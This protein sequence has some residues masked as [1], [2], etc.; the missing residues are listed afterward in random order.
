MYKKTSKESDME[1]MLDILYKMHLDK[2]QMA[3]TPPFIS[4]DINDYEK[5]L[6]IHAPGKITKLPW[7]KR[8]FNFLLRPL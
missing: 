1:D 6:Y 5:M 8:L 7:Y 4:V 3:A 2:M